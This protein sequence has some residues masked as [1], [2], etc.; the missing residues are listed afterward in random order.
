M[1][2]G[3]SRSTSAYSVVASGA[4]AN[5][6]NTSSR[7]ITPIDGANASG[8]E[9]S[10]SSAIR[11]RKRFS[12]D[13]SQDRPPYQSPPTTDPSAQTVISGPTA[14]REPSRLGEGRQR[15][16]ERPERD[17]RDGAREHERAHAAGAQRSSACSVRLLLRRAALR[18]AGAVAKPTDATR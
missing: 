2:G 9:P 16:L 7:P 6:V 13:D 4:S 1:P 3:A 8:A 15:H 11:I 17:R 18:A 5:P 14:P 12:T 10:A